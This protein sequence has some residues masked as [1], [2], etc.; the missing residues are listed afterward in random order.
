MTLAVRASFPSYLFSHRVVHIEL[1]LFYSKLLLY[2][3][4]LVRAFGHKNKFESP[5]FHPC[6]HCRADSNDHLQQFDGLETTVRGWVNEAEVIQYTS[7]TALRGPLV[8]DQG[9]GNY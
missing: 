4:C 5:Q 9:I 1:I 3:A 8:H 7:V 6:C 2:L